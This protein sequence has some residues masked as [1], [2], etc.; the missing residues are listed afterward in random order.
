[1]KS[2]T[3]GSSASLGS[4]SS[5]VAVNGATK[6]TFALNG[7]NIIKFGYEV[8]PYEPINNPAVK[9]GVNQAAVHHFEDFQVSPTAAT[10]C[11]ARRSR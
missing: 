11:S 7:A 4:T 1:M 2:P 5:G 6:E 10:R 3:I 8:I 9:H